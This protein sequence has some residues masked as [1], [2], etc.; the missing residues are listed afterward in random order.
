MYR[1]IKD[2]DIGAGVTLRL[3]NE[4]FSADLYS[5]TDT[6]RAHLREWLP[7]VDG[8][9]SVEKTLAF[10]RLST[11]QDESQ[12]GFNC[13]ILVSGKVAGVIGLHYVD[14]VNRSTSIGYWLGS[15]YEGRGVMTACCKVMVRHCFDILVLNRIEIRCAVG[16]RKSRRIPEKLGFVEEGTLRDSEWLNGRFVDSVVYSMLVRDWRG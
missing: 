10:I 3:L 11:Q 4:E 15:K 13:C 5:L 7:W 1:A 2:Q 6:D 16:N 9:T 12:K 8:C 14:H